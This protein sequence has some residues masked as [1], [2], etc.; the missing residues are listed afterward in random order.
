MTAVS[1]RDREALEQV[2]LS[3]VPEVRTEGHTSRGVDELQPEGRHKHQQCSQPAEVDGAASQTALLTKAGRVVGNQVSAV[4]DTR[5]GAEVTPPA[6]F[7]WSSGSGL[8][9]GGGGGGGGGGWGGGGG[10]GGWR[11]HPFQ[12]GG[13][14]G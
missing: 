2:C 6:E 8:E 7:G 4:G 13:D 5:H 9:V 11:P 3:A 12:D 1:A 10:G 14:K